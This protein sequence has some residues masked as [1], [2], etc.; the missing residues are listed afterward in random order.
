MKTKLQIVIG[1]VLTCLFMISPPVLAIAQPLPELNK[2]HLYVQDH[3]QVLNDS[4]VKNI[5]N[6]GIQLEK[7]TGIEMLVVTMNQVDEPRRDYALRLLREYG[8]GKKGV[9]NGIV[10][11]LNLD[12]KNNAEDR[13][14]EI[15]I[16]YG[17]EGYFNDA[18]VGEIIDNNGL[19]Y[20]HAKKYDEGLMKLYKAM[21]DQCQDAAKFQPHD[22]PWE[23]T[24]KEG[25]SYDLKNLFY[26]DLNWFSY[27]FL[28]GICFFMIIGL[29]V[30]ALFSIKRAFKADMHKLVYEE[31]RD[32]KISDYEEK[33]GLNSQ[34]SS[35]SGS[36]Y[37][38]SS[39]GGYSSSGSGG[40]SNSFGGGSGGGGGAG[41]GF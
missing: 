24:W 19:E 7:D 32:K 28:F 41:R 20:F 1:I 25:I 15:Q 9:N 23:E 13:G 37:Y 14:I 34:S 6:M 21:Y 4:E 11:F 30:Y 8:V 17:L 22:Q 38:G 35:S 27:V 5:N 31:E 3:A 33:Y 26:Y 12:K 39:G 2:E 16:G 29:F 40:S 18:K 10:I 36:S